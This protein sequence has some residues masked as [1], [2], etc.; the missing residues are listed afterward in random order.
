V[1]RTPFTGGLHGIPIF[2]PGT[3]EFKLNNSVLTPYVFTMSPGYL[4]AARTRLLDGR[5]VS[6]HDTTKTPYVAIVNETFAR[7]MFG[8][9]PWVKRRPSDSALFWGAT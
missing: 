2:R 1:S 5:D 3:T 6:W 8:E 7:K 9:T 4:E